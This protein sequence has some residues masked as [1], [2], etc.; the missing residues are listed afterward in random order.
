MPEHFASFSDSFLK[1]LPRALLPRNLFGDTSLFPHEAQSTNLHAPHRYQYKRRAPDSVAD[2][3]SAQYAHKSSSFQTGV[4][5][6]DRRA[7]D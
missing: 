2:E 3:T 7:D 5:A 1:V 4:D 6:V